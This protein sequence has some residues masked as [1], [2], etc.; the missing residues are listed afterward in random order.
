MGIQA[1]IQ[2][3]YHSPVA[4]AIREGDS[5]WLKFQYVE[6]VHVMAVVLVVGSIVI[7]DFRLLG[8][9]SKNW[10][11]SRLERSVL[12]VTWTAFVVAVVAGALLFASN[13]VVYS[14]TGY[15]RAKMLLLL[16]AGVNVLIYHFIFERGRS[17]WDKDFQPPFAVRCSGA[18]SLA[19]WISVIACGRFTGFA[20]QGVAIF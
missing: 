8:W 4:T 14:N 6:T 17:G 10:P 1:I 5:V 7:V 13:A 12:P 20:T 11:I 3:V 9:A 18:I 16:V 19:L 15:F 2:W